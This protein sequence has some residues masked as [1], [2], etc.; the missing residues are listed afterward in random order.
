MEQYSINA[1]MQDLAHATAHLIHGSSEGR[2]KITYAPGH[3]SQAEMEGVNFGYADLEQTLARYQPEQLKE[4]WNRT[5]DGEEFFFIPTPS[6]GLVVDARQTLQPAHWIRSM[7]MSLMASS[8]RPRVPGVS[9]EFASL[10]S[11]R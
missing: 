6:A 1:D 3:L 9:P 7:N 8:M 5:A 10:A 11:G 4:G 2:F